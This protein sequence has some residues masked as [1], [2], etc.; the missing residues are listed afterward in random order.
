[1]RRIR[2]PKHI[3]KAACSLRTAQGDIPFT[4][5]RSSGRRTLTITVDEHGR[6]NVASPYHMEAKEIQSFIHEKSRWILEKVREAQSNKDILS[7]REFAH[8]QEF[9]YLG[10]KHKV[11]VIKE[12]IQRCRISFDAVRGWSVSVPQEL[13]P[14]ER[15]VQIKNKMLQWYRAQAKEILGG[16]IFH[17]SRLMGV[18]PKKIAIRTQK[19]LWGNCD[20]N[21]KTIN[22]NWQI[23]LSPL[24]VIDYVIVHELC[25]LTVPSHSKRFW[26]KV[27]KFMPEYQGYRRWLKVNHLDMV[28]P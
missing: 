15:Q 17:Y 6:V 20:Y 28:I 14:Q 18:E 1:M 25:H 24:K 2:R 5:A 7:Q 11:H 9:L 16:R 21:T 8:G 27:G 10:E 23:V 19:R 22:L 4:W 26:S 12:N 3:V 13:T